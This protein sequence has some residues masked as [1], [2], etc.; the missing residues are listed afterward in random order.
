[1]TLST[2]SNAVSALDINLGRR[3]V[4]GADG[5]D[6]ISNFESVVGSGFD[7][8]ILGSNRAG[9]VLSG[10]AGDD[11]IRSLRGSDS[12]TGGEGSDTFVFE[13]TDVVR[14][15]REY[16]ADEIE[17]FAADDS[18]DVSNFFSGSF[19]ANQVFNLVENDGNTMLSA[20]IGR[21]GSFVDVA[22]LNGVT[23]LTIAGMIDDG[24]LIV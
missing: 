1:M 3:T 2:F 15:R 20:Q 21:G 9:E 18:L 24:M 7:D 19:D 13:R 10:G 5:N 14:G 4:E 6:R 16:G 22:Q 11:V 12:L 23:G 17:D 8:T